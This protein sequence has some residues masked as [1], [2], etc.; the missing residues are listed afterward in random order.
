LGEERV[1]EIKHERGGKL[2][3]FLPLLGV[4]IN[5]VQPSKTISNAPPFPTSPPP[6]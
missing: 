6:P 2:M 5:S 1:F 3:S 4:P